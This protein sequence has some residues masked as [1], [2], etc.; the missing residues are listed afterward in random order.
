MSCL[1]AL[2]KTS[3]IHK[4]LL[5]RPRF[6]LHFTP[7]SSPWLN[8]VE[9][10]FAELTQRKLHRS[11]HRCVTELENDIRKWI[12]EWDKDPRPFRLVKTA[13]EI[14]EPSP[15]TADYVRNDSRH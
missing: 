13:D 2:P 6:H 10:W 15:P 5:G 12:N 4:R 9:R 1:P 3:E 7:A 8:L 11:A 14:L